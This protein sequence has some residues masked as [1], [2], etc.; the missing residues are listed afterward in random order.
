MNIKKAN[1]QTKIYARRS[2]TLHIFC[3]MPKGYTCMKYIIVMFLLLR[4]MSAHNLACEQTLAGGIWKDPRLEGP[5]RNWVRVKWPRKNA[6]HLPSSLPSTL[7]YFL[8]YL[9]LFSPSSS[10]EPFHT[11]HETIFYILPG[12]VQGQ[13][14][15][16]QKW[17]TAKNFARFHNYFL[18]S[19]MVRSKKNYVVS[20]SKSENS[21]YSAWI[22]IVPEPVWHTLE[23]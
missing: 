11:L 21:R 5:R 15:N 14:Q 20:C 13:P 23:I 18:L 17:N 2:L 3:L 6:W 9:F 16:C 4:C 12:F 8:S 10:R 1:K 19:T 7:F 22:E